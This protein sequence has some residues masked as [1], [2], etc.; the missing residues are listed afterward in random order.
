MS[1]SSKILTLSSF[2]SSLT[3]SETCLVAFWLY[4]VTF[5]PCYLSWKYL[6]SQGYTVICVVG[7]GVASEQNSI[8]LIGF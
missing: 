8:S 5:K 6:V 2:Y 3:S 1:S 7:A 4:S